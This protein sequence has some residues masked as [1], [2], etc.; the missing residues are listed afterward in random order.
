MNEPS[1]PALPAERQPSGAIEGEYLAPGSNPASGRNWKAAGG[2]AVGIGLFIAKFKAILIGLLNLKWILLGG[3]FALTGASF[4]TSIWF[5]SLFY[6]WKFA[7][8]F[9]VLIAIHE[10]GHVAFVRGFHLSAPAVYFVPGFGAFTT[11]KGAPQSVFQE[12]LIA[13]GGPLFGGLAGAACYAYGAATGSDF[14][15]AAAYIAFFLN[16]FNMIPIA[17]LD[18]GKMTAAISPRLWIAGFVFVAI[19]AIAF[20][21]WNP[22]LLILIALSVPRVVQTFRGQIDARYADVLPGE[23]GAISVAYFAL[24]AALLAGPSSAT[25]PRAGKPLR[26]RMRRLCLLAAIVAA[27]IAFFAVRPAPTSGPAVRDFEA[28]YSAGVA[29]GYRN[30]PYSR[31]VWRTERTIPGVVSGRDE[32]LPFVGPPFGLPLWHAFGSIPWGAATIAWEAILALSLAIVAYGSLRLAGGRIDGLDAL[33]VLVVLGGFGPLTSGFALGQVAI[34]A[35]AAVLLFPFLLGPRFVLAAAASASLAALQPNLAL[36]LAA[37][38]AGRRS[39]IA[40]AFAA[41]IAV[42]GSVLAVGGWDG[43]AH[44]LA[45][46]R[47]HAAAERF[48]AIQTTPGAV[49]R[50]LGASPQLAGAFGIAFAVIAV[51]GVGLQCASRRYAPNDRLAL[52][53]AALPLLSPFAHEHDLS[54]VF[55]PALA[56]VRRARGATWVVAAAAF[57]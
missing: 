45:A 52:A 7:F 53:C 1:Q 51:A 34:V 19:A 48:I 8:V 27:A 4:L 25:S 22:I 3:K 44:Y 23:R 46:L 56:T 41:T 18:G 15:I 9:V 47:D 12:S 14:W 16:L 2:T 21:W 24:L 37:R 26:S 43:I 11:W 49:A 55:F 38:L 35:C 31:D 50:A 20:H 36:V 40:L 29:W 57:L 5:Y 39:Y 10:L 30:D 33:A 54:I 32:V 42:G 17:F 6:G 13:F 28:Y